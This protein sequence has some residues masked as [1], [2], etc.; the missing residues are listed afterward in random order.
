MRR[1]SNRRIDVPRIAGLIAVLAVFA[2]GCLPAAGAELTLMVSGA[3]AEP[4]RD[5]AQDFAGRHGDTVRVIIG[6]SQSQE[7]RIKAGEKPDLIE[8]NSDAMLALEKQQLLLP[9]TRVELARANIAV[10][11]PA[12]VRSPKIDTPED[13]KRTLVSAR[14]IAL[15]DPKIRSQATEAIQKLLRRLGVQDAVLAKVVPG[16]T[17][18]DAVQKLA[19]GEADLAISFESEI[20]P[21]RGAKL[22]GRVPAALQDPTTFEGAIGASSSNPETARAMLHEITGESGRMVLERAGLEPV[23]P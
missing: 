17:G 8:V 19:D 20:L 5:I 9:G 18:L 4:I 10:A 15:T 14:R 2:F 22:A 7:R 13:L 23:G 12:D 11:V 21:I 3:M 6:T 16:A 1:A